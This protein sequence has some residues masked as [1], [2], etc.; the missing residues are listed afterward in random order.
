[1][2]GEQLKEKLQTLDVNLC[3]LAAKLGYSSDQR[4]H[5]KLNA[6]DVK[7]GFLADVARVLDM[8]ISWFF[9]EATGGGKNNQ[10]IIK[11][12]ALARNQQKT[13]HSQQETIES[14]TKLLVK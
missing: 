13:I 14:L 6:D 8:P 3:E 1:M 4:L 11:L 7:T 5:S 9:D 12:T 10:T 2:S